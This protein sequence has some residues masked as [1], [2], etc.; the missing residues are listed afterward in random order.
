[1]EGGREEG[2]R[3]SRREAASQTQK[4]ILT[5]ACQEALVVNLHAHIE[6]VHLHLAHHVPVLDQ[7]PFLFPPGS[8]MARLGALSNVRQN[9]LEMRWLVAFTAGTAAA[10]VATLRREGTMQRRDFEEHVAGR[11]DGRMLGGGCRSDCRGEY[12]ERPMLLLGL[13]ILSDRGSDAGGGVGAGEETARDGVED[14]F[15]VLDEAAGGQKRYQACCEC[16]G[17]RKDGKPAASTAGF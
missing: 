17:V 11:I 16:C 5:Y 4:N 14:H 9:Q 12:Q 8:H 3:T 15:C 13:Q 1:M 6:L 7:I 2:W 10:A